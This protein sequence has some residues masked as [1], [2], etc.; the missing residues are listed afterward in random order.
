MHL[1]LIS[2]VFLLL[3]SLG[4]ASSVHAWV[5]PEHREISIVAVQHLDPARKASF[6]NLWREA[7]GA[8]EHRLCEQGAD[9]AQGTGPNCIDWA[10]LA[11]IAGDH[12]CSSQDMSGI[13][14]ESKWIL[15]IADVAAQLKIDLSHIA[16]LPHPS[17]VPD[18]NSPVEDLRR[19][20]ESASARAARINALRTADNRLQ[21]ADPEYA[22]RAG[23]N[24]AH[25]LLGRPYT[26]ITP[27]EYGFLAVRPG[28]EI[29]AM[30]VWWRF[31]ASALQKA[32]RLAN[33]K[34]AK[35]E[36]AMLARSILFDE[37]FAIHFLQDIFSA[38]HIAGSWGNTAQRKGT[39][40]FYNEVGL[41][42]IPWG[43][44]RQSV[45]VMGDAHMRP[46]DAEYAAVAI[47][48]S[49]EQVLD[50][51]T[52]IPRTPSVPYAPVAPLAP[53]DFN[54]CKNNI[55]VQRP[56]ALRMPP[57]VL[58]LAVEVLQTAPMPGLGPGLGA[59]PRFR[60]ELG[61]F[62]GLAGMIDG[63]YISSGFMGSEGGGVIGGVD[64]SFR[65]GLGLDGVLGDSGDGLTY[66]AV[67]LRGDSSSTNS[68]SQS[69][70]AQQGGNLTAAIP[71]HVGIS[72]RL[73][74]PFFL[75]PG[76]LL[77]LS[78]LYV[79]APDLYKQIGIHA[80][81][82]GLLGWQ[83]GWATPIG[84]F[85]FVLGRELGVTLQGLLGADRV[86]TPSATPGGTPQL[87]SY[88]SLYFDVPV[89]EYRAFRAFSNN[90]S[91]ALLVQ[92]FTGFSVPYA[93]S[94][95]SPAGAPQVDMHTVWSV[96]GL[97]FVLDW[98]YYP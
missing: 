84:R 93:T 44:N 85:Q 86:L 38:G 52:G 40:D 74:M 94:V 39:H 96:V 65:V 42:V 83:S 46:E 2:P 29:N 71:S 4:A 92:L 53:D 87:V 57:E 97:R 64:L 49:L 61:P 75:I 47:R 82:G 5:Y 95:I 88:K 98:R 63:R 33:E 11:A 43:A 62:V 76:D 59:M 21:R 24:N 54:V 67:G 36:R 18:D 41:E 30:S 32:T 28:A 56:E 25:F 80:V 70:G 68:F 78:P 60:S 58:S 51:A 7:R 34:L 55:Q 26:D 19:R 89:L 81:N 79:L 6:D 66:L 31:H 17:Q 90:Q 8:Y 15:A 20:A 27:L 77:L 23:S 14:L 73:R 10:A 16:I 50:T 91:G 69:A 37:A 1:A 72:T 12:S 3:A 9:R 48:T 22:T 35:E 13:V 45:I